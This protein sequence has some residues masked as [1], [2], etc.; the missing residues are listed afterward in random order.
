MSYVIE[1]RHCFRAATSSGAA[2][3]V[4]TVSVDTRGATTLANEQVEQR[5]GLE[6]ARTVL[7]AV[8]NAAHKA[9]GSA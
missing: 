1:E 9:A 3:V 6:D 2:Y 4:V 5:A 7:A 8:V